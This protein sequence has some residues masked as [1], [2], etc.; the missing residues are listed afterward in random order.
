[1]ST[2]IGEYSVV[3]AEVS[4]KPPVPF[5]SMV[6]VADPCLLPSQQRQLNYKIILE[7]NKPMCKLEIHC[8]YHNR[9]LALDLVFLTDCLV[10][11]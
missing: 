6:Q 7:V 8:L 11:S 9:S 10:T 5:A 2:V 4:D 1:M 3:H